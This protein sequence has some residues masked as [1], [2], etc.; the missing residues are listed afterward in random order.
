[1]AELLAEMKVAQMAGQTGELRAYQT[2]ETS[3]D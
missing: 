1:M 3:A 2:A